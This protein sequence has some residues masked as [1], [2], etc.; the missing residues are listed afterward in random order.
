MKNLLAGSIFFFLF[1]ALQP[2]VKAGDSWR[3]TYHLSYFTAEYSG[4]R[5]QI[6]EILKPQ[7]QR[8]GASAADLQKVTNSVYSG[9][10][11][12]DVLRPFVDGKNV[13][14]GLNMRWISATP[15]CR[16][17]LLSCDATR[18]DS[19]MEISSI[20]NEQVLKPLFADDG[21]LIAERETFQADVLNIGRSDFV[22]SKDVG[23]TWNHLSAPV[24]CRVQGVWCRLIAQTALKYILISTK[25][26]AS[27]SEFEDVTVNTTFDGAT[28]WTSS[29][30]RWRG[31]RTPT[32]V[33]VEGDIL[34]GLP[35]E[36]GEFV[37]L[38][39]L[40]LSTRKVE[41]I[42]T[43]IRTDTWET[44]HG[45]QV[46]SYS[47]GYLLQLDAEKPMMIGGAGVFFIPGGKDDMP[48]RLIW[49]S[50]GMPLGDLQTSRRAIVIGTWNPKVLVGRNFEQKIH[51]SLDGGLTWKIRNVPQDL[52]GGTMLLSDLDVWIFSANAI[53]HFNLADADNDG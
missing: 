48:A 33:A 16:N 50:G 8:Q 13:L 41:E 15:D 30:E 43:N 5:N 49:P 10:A 46:V 6:L 24:D 14:V 28:T 23:K 29:I 25:I 18:P 21:I 40:K 37:T 19:C 31:I 32:A 36:Q 2:V 34:V 12:R 44:H 47:G 20:P 39:S 26:D 17:L 38:S 22:V 9:L 7:L 42:K 45:G 51:Y 11:P 4:C 53:Q 27:K 3:G 52:L 35:R 1:F